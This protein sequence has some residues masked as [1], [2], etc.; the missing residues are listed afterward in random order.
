MFIWINGFIVDQSVLNSECPPSAWCRMSQSA[1]DECVC[2]CGT[3]QIHFS[4]LLT[5][6]RLQLESVRVSDHQA[7]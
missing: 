5:A 6:R 4:S 7:Q 1:T 2:V 3:E